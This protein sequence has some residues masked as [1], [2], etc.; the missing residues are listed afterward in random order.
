MLCVHDD[1]VAAVDWSPDGQRIA[2]ASRDRTGRVWNAWASIEVVVAK[3]R[4]RLHRELTQE[5]RQRFTLPLR[6]RTA[7]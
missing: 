2:T 4:E 5:E 7:Q 6:S 1:G 3:A